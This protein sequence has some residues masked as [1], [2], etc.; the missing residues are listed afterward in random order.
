V[1]GQ[2]RLIGKAEWA[3]ALRRTGHTFVRARGYDAA[4]SLTFFS[5]LTLFPAALTVLSALA[6]VDGSKAVDFLLQ[7]IDEVATDQAVETIRGPLTQFTSFSDPGVA[8]L[9]GLALAVWTG[10][11]YSAAFGRA[12]NTLYG[13][14]E[15]RRI[16]KFRG[17]MLVVSLLLTVGLSVVLLL[18]LGTPT[19]AD[20]V[21]RV[22]GIGNPWV[23]LWDV[24]RWP[25]MIALAAA[26]IELLYF[27]TPTVE[28][29]SIRWFSSGALLALAGW[30]IATTGFWLYVT[31]LAH[32][33]E[34]YGWVG[35]ALVVLL[36]LF[37]SNLVLV[38]GA[39]LDAELV[40]VTQLRQGVES[41]AT[42]RVPMRDTSR[43]L[44]I[45]RSLARDIADGRAIREAAKQHAAPESSGFSR[46]L[47]EA[48][49]RR[50]ADMSERGRENPDEKSVQED[51]SIPED[52]DF[53]T[54]GEPMTN[55]GADEKAEAARA[56]TPGN[57][58][59]D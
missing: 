42:I 3:Y 8:F 25:A 57:P 19:V 27:F 35:G 44:V 16:W 39:G 38:L 10:S 58:L 14:Q 29:Q 32:Y 55:D 31:N 15:G 47:A 52:A 24:L 18:L 5:A 49:R 28:R 26:L 9:I 34:L 20:A 23:P 48:L 51:F 50:L 4:A 7:V 56:A 30:A 6:L 21:A 43:N 13:V 17:L 11:G 2:D 46:S 37:L 12:L 41:E 54:P 45:A 36:W 53:T 1:S 22:A 59:E 33:D 40:R